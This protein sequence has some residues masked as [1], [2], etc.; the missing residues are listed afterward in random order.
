MKE[1]DHT[2]GCIAMGKP[3]ISASFPAWANSI[4]KSS[5]RN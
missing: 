2:I 4:L 1:E 5:L 3:E